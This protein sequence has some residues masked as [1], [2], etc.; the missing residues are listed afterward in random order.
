MEV[1]HPH[2]DMR[3]VHSTT[4]NN[5][6]VPQPH[7]CQVNFPWK[8][9][10]T[11]IESLFV[12]GVSEKSCASCCR[13]AWHTCCGQTVSCTSAHTT[14]KSSHCAPSCALLWFWWYLLTPFP[15]SPLSST[16]SKLHSNP[17]LPL[18]SLLT[19]HT[20][21]RHHRRRPTSTNQ[22]TKTTNQTH[23]QTGTNRSKQKQTQTNTRTNKHK[24]HTDTQ[25]NTQTHA[26]KQTH[27]Q[28][29]N[30]NQQ[31]QPATTNTNE[32]RTTPYNDTMAHNNKT[33]Q[34]NNTITQQQQPL[35]LLTLLTR[36]WVL[37]SQP[38]QSLMRVAWHKVG[39]STLW[40]VLSGRFG[41]AG[42]HPG[43]CGSCESGPMMG[44]RRVDWRCCPSRV[45]IPTG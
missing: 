28:P 43:V 13:S 34:R 7:C 35:P 18:L 20:H 3:T 2:C 31:Q 16:C 4:T 11:R 42:S 30:Q 29:T 6:S 12:I 32:P 44:G 33:R 14:K 24:Q 8:S 17:F 36:E 9:S 1:E 5:P 45:G 27:N 25:T 38:C 22:L 26:H 37:S 23:K 21:S 19:L 41:E 15:P 40:T 10:S 39:G